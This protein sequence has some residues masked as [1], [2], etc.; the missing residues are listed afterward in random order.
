MDF[1]AAHPKDCEAQAIIMYSWNEHSE[2][3]GLCPTMG[4]PPEYVPDTRWLD[5]A[6]AALSSWRTKKICIQN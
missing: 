4:K 6:A 3:G 2:G 1:V 5:E